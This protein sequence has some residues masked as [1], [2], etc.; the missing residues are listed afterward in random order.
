MIDVQVSEH[1]PITHSFLLEEQLFHD[2]DGLVDT[3]DCTHQEKVKT[4]FRP[5]PIRAPISASSIEKSCELATP[6]IEPLQSSIL[7]KLPFSSSTLDS[8]KLGNS[9]SSDEIVYVPMLLSDFI[10]MRGGVNSILPKI[11]TPT[12]EKSPTRA[13]RISEEEEENL[14]VEDSDESRDSPTHSPKASTKKSTNKITKPTKSRFRHGRLLPENST[15]VLRVWYNAHS[16]HP[17]PSQE[18]KEELAQSSSLSI[19]QI[20]N[21][22]M[23]TRAREKSKPLKNT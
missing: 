8:V 10:A 9:A 5:K 12:R 15:C 2:I 11:S 4:I 3:P 22:F 14:I 18:E 13:R 23:N 7:S 6:T 16:D 21:W 19:Q 17:Y 1:R 20:N